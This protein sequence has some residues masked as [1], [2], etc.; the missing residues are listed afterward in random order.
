MQKIPWW[1]RW[2]RVGSVL[3]LLLWTIWVIYRERKRVLRARARGN[4][5]VQPNIEVLINV[6]VAFRQTAI[7]LGILMIKLGQ[8]LS[9][10]ADL[11]PERALEVLITLQDEVPP[12]PFE[13]VVYMIE[14]E[15]GKPVSEIF[16]VLEP[17]CT[18]AASLGQVHKAVLANT[19][20]TVAVK[21]QRPNIEQLVRMDLRTLRFVIWLITKLVDPGD[22]IDLWGIYREFRRTV[23]EEVNFTHEAANAQRFRAMF[24]DDP[25]I[26]IPRVYEQYVTRRIIVLEWIDGIKINDYALLDAFEFDR[27][28]V[29]RRTVNAYFRQFFE[30]GFFHADPHPGNIFVKRGSAAKKP[31]IAFL[32]FGMTG[33][34]TNYTRRFLREL[35]LAIVARDTHTVVQTLIKLG[36]IGEGANLVSIERAMD[37][38]MDQYIGITLGEYRDLHMSEIARDIVELLYG[39]PF[40]I[41]AHFA[42]S[43]RAVSTLVG[44]ATGLAP[45]FN[46]IE[47]ATPYARRFLGLDTENI[48][49][50]V[51]EIIQ[52]FIE[53]GRV[54]STLPRA[55]ERFMTHIQT[56]QVEVRLANFLDRRSHRIPVSIGG[57]GFSIALVSL[58][59]LAGGIYLTNVHLYTPGWFCLGLAGVATLGMIVRK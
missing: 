34:I 7:K 47:E 44:V 49:K 41:P 32:D 23:F 15:F 9:S 29:A 5:E 33:S 40:H 48:G 52:Q 57:S 30:E 59:S 53:N 22:F 56:G 13:H 6:L 10:R 43:G 26:Y 12:E 28:E 31:V 17:T 4:Y 20:E 27:M 58:S 35:F 14:S 55:V 42:F 38:I 11:L 3:R 54:I 16:S 19:G 50:M 51:Q 36:F 2:I 21:I 1:Q 46:F 8:F 45:K 25:C 37:I 24:K 39:Q 18:A